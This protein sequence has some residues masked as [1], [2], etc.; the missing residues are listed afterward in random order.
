M[1]SAN[2]DARSSI[3]TVRVI[4]TPENVRFDYRLAGP[5]RRLMAM[6]IDYAFILMIV[7]GLLWISLLLIGEGSLG[8]VF[9]TFFILQWGYAGLMETFC[10]GQTLGKMAMRL[11]VVSENGLPINSQQAFLR[12]FLRTADLLLGGSTATVSMMF[13][14]MFQRLGDRAAGTIVV[15]EQKSGEIETP[16]A[17]VT[18]K[19]SLLMVPASFR[20]DRDLIE[21]LTLYMARRNKLSPARRREI[22][23]WLARHFIRNWSL[24]AN[25]D[26]DQLLCLLYSR[27]V[28][29]APRSKGY[30]LKGEPVNQASPKEVVA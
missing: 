13:S 2:S 8:L 6:V 21:G 26:P 15:I 14:P 9:I 17:V 11:R 16:A 7:F 20:A 25:T 23:Y 4:I 3:D 5:T 1:V 10:N 12:G 19:V 27:S 18:E 22:A 28:A 29:E 24:P 30:R